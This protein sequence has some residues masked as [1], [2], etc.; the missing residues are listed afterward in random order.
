MNFKKALFGVC[1]LMI[2]LFAFIYFSGAEG[3]EEVKGSANVLEAVEEKP[4]ILDVF[5]GV[6]T[7]SFD[8]NYLD[9][10]VDFENNLFYLE[11]VW[12]GG[13]VEGFEDLLGNQ[14]SFEVVELSTYPGVVV[15]LDVSENLERGRE[16]N[17]YVGEFVKGF[18]L[19]VGFNEESLNEKVVVVRG[20]GMKK[21][22]V[23]WSAI[24]QETSLVLGAAGLNDL[25]NSDLE[26][27]YGI[28][29]EGILTAALYPNFEEYKVSGES[30]EKGSLYEV[31]STLDIWGIV[32]EDKRTEEFYVR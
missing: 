7:E 3:S 27:Y 31:L 26:F 25:I 9:K 10:Y 29:G 30:G 20:F 14:I 24:S 23:D 32:P 11:G 8:G 15:R 28:S 22:S 18:L 4:N 6:V 2:G 21:L 5:D 1:V 16:L 12:V 19:G 17:E 13:L